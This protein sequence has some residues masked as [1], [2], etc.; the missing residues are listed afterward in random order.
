M[1]KG[2]KREKKKG[3]L[4]IGLSSRGGSCLDPLKLII[5]IIFEPLWVYRAY[6]DILTSIVS[7][8]HFWKRPGARDMTILGSHVGLHLPNI[9]FCWVYE[10]L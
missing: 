6:G 9:I 3:T 1:E 2:R 7:H 10:V 8:S 5:L 4:L